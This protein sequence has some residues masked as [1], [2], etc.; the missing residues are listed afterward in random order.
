M[1][2]HDSDG[3]KVPGHKAAK[4]SVRRGGTQLLAGGGVVNDD[5]FAIK[6]TLAFF[7]GARYGLESGVIDIADKM[8]VDER[9]SERTDFRRSVIDSVLIGDTSCVAAAVVATAA[10]AARR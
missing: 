10:I 8:T 9:S 7:L 2:A 1:S 6:A 3:A 4:D 5:D